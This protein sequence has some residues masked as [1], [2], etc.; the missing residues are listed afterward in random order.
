MKKLAI[1]I[2]YRNREEHLKE[3]LKVVPDFVRRGL[4][5]P[6]DCHIIVIEQGNDKPFN[7]GKLLNIGFALVKDQ[8]DYFCFHDV[9]MMPTRADYSYPSIPTHLA[10]DVS[11]FRHWVGKGLAYPTY[12]GGV[13]LFNKED[14]VRVNGFSNGYWGHGAEDDDLLMRINRSGLKWGRRHGIYESLPHAQAPKPPPSQ[15]SP[16]A[17]RLLAIWQGKEI[18]HSGLSDLEFNVKEEK[19]YPTH[20]VY[21]VDF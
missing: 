2:P 3:F 10:A 15:L 14:F 16:N 7:R 11:Q 21:T 8:Y 17:E 1:I 19:K 4:D 6:I 9:D 5:A 12:F 18:D 20:T 13:V